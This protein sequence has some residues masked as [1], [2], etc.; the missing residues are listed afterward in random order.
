MRWMQELQTVERGCEYRREE[1]EPEACFPQEHVTSEE[2]EGSGC[3]M[4]W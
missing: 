3:M 1:N 4:G 2:Q